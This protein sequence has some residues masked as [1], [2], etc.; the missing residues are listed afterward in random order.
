MMWILDVRMKK[1][2]FVVVYDFDDIYD[3]NIGDVKWL[4]MGYF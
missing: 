3:V 2:K 1:C 4:F